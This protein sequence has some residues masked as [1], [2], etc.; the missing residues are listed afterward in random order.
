LT[1]LLRYMMEFFQTGNDSQASFQE[2]KGNNLM[3]SN[4]ISK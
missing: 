3:E 2:E 1:Y 4:M